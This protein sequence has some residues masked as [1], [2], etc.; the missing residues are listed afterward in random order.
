MNLLEIFWG[1]AYI[2][3]LLL[4]RA[5]VGCQG[6]HLSGPLHDDKERVCLC[7]PKGKDM[8]TAK[9]NVK[10]RQIGQGQG[11]GEGR[12]SVPQVLSRHC[13]YLFYRIFYG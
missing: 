8:S 12:A 2:P 11:E 6:H 9:Q 1:R 4:H 13:V 7:H 3:C 10:E 5:G